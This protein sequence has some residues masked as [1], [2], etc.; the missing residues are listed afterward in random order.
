MQEWFGAAL[1]TFFAKLES[2]FICGLNVII[3]RMGV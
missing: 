1:L 3:F 2:F